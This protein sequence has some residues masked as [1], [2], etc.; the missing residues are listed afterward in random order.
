MYHSRIDV[1]TSARRTIEGESP[2]PLSS[3]ILALANG[4][5]GPHIKVKINQGT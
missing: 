4:Y 5:L 2:Y 3:G 1:E